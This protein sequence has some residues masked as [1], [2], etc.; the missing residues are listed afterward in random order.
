VFTRLLFTT[1]ILAVLVIVVGAW[2]RLTDAGLGCPDWPGC[3]GYLTS[4]PETQQ[5]IEAAT[6]QDPRGSY[7]AGKAMREMTHRYLA[8]ALGL[9]ILGLTALCF[10]GR[11]NSR[12]TRMMSALLALVVFQA[13]LGMWTVTLQLKPLIVALHL[14]GGFATLSLL[15]WLWMRHR[16]WPTPSDTGPPLLHKLCLLVIGVL[17]VQ[18]FLGGW[19]SSNYAA[20]ACPDFPTCRGQWWPDSINFSEAFVLWRGLGINYEFGVLDSPARTAIHVTHRIG[21]LVTTLAILWLAIA[22]IR[23]KIPVLR[24][25]AVAQL[26]L[27]VLQLA[28]GI[29]NV[30]LQLPIAIATAHNIVA[31][32]LLLSLLT[33][34]R[35]VRQFRLE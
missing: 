3:Y 4:L 26:H 25:C 22:S 30:T 13:L 11:G 32:F 28:L 9:M 14:L 15:W 7:D 10:W 33:Q 12:L 17:V 6:A 31:A 19:T 16:Q 24:R 20:L 29:G 21:A 5:E 2:V 35:L 23:T 18:I 34:L 1:L 27:L 8:G